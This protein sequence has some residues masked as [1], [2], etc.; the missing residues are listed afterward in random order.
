MVDIMT[1]SRQISMVA[2]FQHDFQRS[3][4]LTEQALADVSDDEFFR[5]PGEAVNSIALIVK[6][7]S[8]NLASRWS[9]FLTTDGDKPNR[10]RDQEFLITPADSRPHLM[11]AWEN[12]WQ[13]VTDTLA[14]LGDEDLTRQITI[15][16]EPHTVLQALIRSATHTAYHAGQILYLARW[17]RPESGWH[18]IPPGGSQQHGPGKYLRG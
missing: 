17:L 2:A 18:T 14:S 10:E 1:D 15:R 11:A 9:D 7:M 5:K 13:I 8:G 12:A 6:H 4:R 16:G 3:R